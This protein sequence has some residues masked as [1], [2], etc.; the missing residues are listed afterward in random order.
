MRIE[1]WQRFPG[2]G[3]DRAPKSSWCG[4][5]KAEWSSRNQHL[6]ALEH[7]QLRDLLAGRQA[8]S[9]NRLHSSLGG[10]GSSCSGSACCRQRW[11]GIMDGC[12]SYT[13]VH[14]AMRIVCSQSCVVEAHVLVCRLCREPE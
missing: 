5:V 12:T 11:L 7:E 9:W 1:R 3:A 10:A 8:G 6:E 14:I 2:H 13:Q 4:P